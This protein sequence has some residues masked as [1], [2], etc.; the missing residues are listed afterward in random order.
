MAI[1]AVDFVAA[2]P[3]FQEAYDARPGSVA[4]A[5]QEALPHVSALHYG[6]A[7]QQGVFLMTAH[8]L[9]VSP[10]GQEMRLIKW[11][12]RTTYSVRFDRLSASRPVRTLVT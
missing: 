11:D 4:A 7:Y 2:F 3:E 10:Y 8:I 1:T 5:I 9:S 12:D 6:S